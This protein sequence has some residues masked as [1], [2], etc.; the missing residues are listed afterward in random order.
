MRDE[1]T[2]EERKA[3]A[4][5]EIG[6]DGVVIVRPGGVVEKR[7]LK[8][9]RKKPKTARA[10]IRKPLPK[11][12]SDE[13][14]DG[15]REAQGL[16]EHRAELC[17]DG[18]EKKAWE[19]LAE[20]CKGM[21]D[22]RAIDDDQYQF[23]RDK[24]R[25]YREVLMDRELMLTTEQG[26]GLSEVT[27]TANEGVAEWKWLAIEMAYE[28]LSPLQRVCL[29]MHV[30]GRLEYPDIAAALNIRPSAVG[31][32][33]SR[34]RQTLKEKALPLVKRVFRERGEDLYYPEPKT[35]RR[36]KNANVNSL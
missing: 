3:D 17:G 1:R 25:H 34:A 8:L 6:N 28:L 14:A 12:A 7:D 4:I 5:R 10:T 2:A 18:H 36:N 11:K 29:E 26:G 33:V 16:A 15:Y 22:T 24:A 30:A 32:Y 23:Q 13:L 19:K 21:A 9:G 31:M 35:R 27:T 20:Y